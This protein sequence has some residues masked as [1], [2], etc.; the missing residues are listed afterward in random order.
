MTEE[1]IKIAG[2]ERARA[3]TR[4]WGAREMGWREEVLKY[5]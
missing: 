4:R 3:I 1:K 2:Y 5:V